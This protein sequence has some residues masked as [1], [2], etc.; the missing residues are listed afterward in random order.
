MDPDSG[1]SG[2]R[3]DQAGGRKEISGVYGEEWVEGEP[4]PLQTKT[5]AEK[6]LKKVREKVRAN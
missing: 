1:V 6:E 2:G 3:E 4:Q 5:R